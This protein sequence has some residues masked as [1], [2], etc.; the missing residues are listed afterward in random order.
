[1]SAPSEI[2]RQDEKISVVKQA[3]IDN[4]KSKESTLRSGNRLFEQSEDLIQALFDALNS[5]VTS[6]NIHNGKDKTANQ[7]KAKIEKK[8]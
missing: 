8:F 7:K 1:V 2:E 5:G 4:V 3:S 6:E